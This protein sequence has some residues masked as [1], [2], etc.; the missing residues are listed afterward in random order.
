LYTTD[1]KE[2]ETIPNIKTGGGTKEAIAYIAKKERYE[3]I[4]ICI[5]N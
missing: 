3:R 5:M 1:T 4:W 2:V